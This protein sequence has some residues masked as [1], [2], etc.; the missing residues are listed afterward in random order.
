MTIVCQTCTTVGDPN[1]TDTT[2]TP[3]T[4]TMQTSM[5]AEAVMEDISDAD[6]ITTQIFKFYNVI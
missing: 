5:R 1:G 2:T 4:A 3:T 6:R